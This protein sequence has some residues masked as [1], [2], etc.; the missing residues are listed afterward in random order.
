[1]DA[2]IWLVVKETQSKK[3]H[4]ADI[5]S[6][7]LDEI[8]SAREAKRL[9]QTNLYGDRFTTITVRTRGLLSEAVHCSFD[10]V[11]DNYGPRPPR[12]A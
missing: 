11:G 7:W 4:P 2:V 10:H 12:P 5:M 8:N 9:T 1:M 3:V 6:A